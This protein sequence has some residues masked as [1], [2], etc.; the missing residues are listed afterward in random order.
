MEKGILK[1]PRPSS[2]R[3][4]SRNLPFHPCGEG[5][6]RRDHDVRGARRFPERNTAVPPASTYMSGPEV[7][8]TPACSFFGN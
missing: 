7:F 1:K 6:F 4:T 3:R 5:E 8:L 2:R